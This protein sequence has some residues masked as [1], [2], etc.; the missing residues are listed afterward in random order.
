M[1]GY[2]SDLYLK[3]NAIYY[4]DELI[5]K[6]SDIMLQGNHNYENIM[7]AIAATKYI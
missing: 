7:C 4:H 3:D 5:I 6:T 2:N 1:D